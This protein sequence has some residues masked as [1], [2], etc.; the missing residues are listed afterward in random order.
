MDVE[1]KG[2]QEEN[3]DDVKSLIKSSF[4]T[5]ANTSACSCNSTVLSFLFASSFNC[6]N[7]GS[8]FSKKTF[9]PHTLAAF[10]L[11][12]FP[13]KA[14]RTQK[15]SSQLSFHDDSLT[16]HGHPTDD[17]EPPC[18]GAEASACDPS[19]SQAPFDSCKEKSTFARFCDQSGQH[20]C[21]AS[22]PGPGGQIKDN[23]YTPV[24]Q[25]LPRVEPLQIVPVAPTSWF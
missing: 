25:S 22:D 6:W 11:H 18:H 1:P 7:C 8:T 9:G 24:P 17:D 2:G 21:T 16:L 4:M 14:W 23:P 3:Y 10:S 12:V 15:C 19:H 13:E 5:W 20:G